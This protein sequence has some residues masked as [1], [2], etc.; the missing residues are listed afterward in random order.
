[1]ARNKSKKKQQ[2]KKAAGRQLGKA[3]NV[4]S[5]PSGP[6]HKACLSHCAQE[7]AL[8]LS[9]PFR[10]SNACVPL[11]PCLPSQRTTTFVRGNLAVGTAGY[12]YLLAR[13]QAAAMNDIE[14][15]YGSIA[16]FTGSAPTDSPDTGVG[17]AFSNS[18]FAQADFDQSLSW[19][20]VAWGARIRYT[21]T[22]LE[23]GGTVF[24]R[25]DPNGV[26][27]DNDSNTSILAN[28]DTQLLPVDRKWKVITWHPTSADDMAYRTT[29]PPVVGSAMFGFFG[30]AGVTYEYEIF[31]HFEFQGSKAKALTMGVEDTVGTYAVMQA[32]MRVSTPGAS[33]KPAHQTIKEVIS[34]A[35]DVITLGSRVKSAVETGWGYAK[36]AEKYFVR[37]APAIAEAAAPL[38]LTL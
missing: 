22:E 5:L 17:S 36:A 37:N 16:T 38:L 15:V 13:P 32:A 30:T 28:I 9:D 24:G 21:G 23:R 27:F 29:S 26:S 20:M 31:A 8:V 4:R 6:T 18:P 25:V 33:S 10:P 35:N 34:T 2:Q 7:Y 14:C 19:R 3:Q 11:S 12:G 1:M